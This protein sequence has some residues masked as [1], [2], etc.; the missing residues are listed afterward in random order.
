MKVA[1]IAGVLTATMT[2]I[3]MTLNP[4]VHDGARK[5][6][7]GQPITVRNDLESGEGASCPPAIFIYARGSTEDGNMGTL[8]PIIASQL[9]EEH[10]KSEIWIQGVGGA[11]DALLED[12]FLPRGTTTEAIDE[13]VRLFQEAN[14]KCPEAVMIAGGYSQGAAVA[15]AAITDWPLRNQ[16]AGTV[17][18]GYTQ[19]KQNRGRIP[20]YPVENTKIFCNKGDLVC[21]GILQVAA[22]HLA[23][24]DAAANEAPKFLTERV[25]V[26]CNGCSFA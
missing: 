3:G 5:I 20:G 18:F 22:P 11:Y 8:G 12:N 7:S 9:E 10:G 4:V 24:G 15:A 16:I 25:G 2:V 1:T 19:N 14:R 17:L 21:E 23:Y 13:M 6:G 26:A